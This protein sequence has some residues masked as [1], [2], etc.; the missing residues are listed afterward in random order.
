MRLDGKIAIVT[1]A[2]SGIGRATASRLAA[3][4]ASLVL[5]DL[6]PKTLDEIAQQ[7][8]K[9]HGV[10]V[11]PAPGDVSREET[12]AKIAGT[13][14]SQ[15]GRVDILVNDAGIHH[16]ADITETSLE[17]WNRVIG[18][19]LT[20]MFLVSRAIIPIML[21][22]R[23]GAIVNLASI[24]SFVGQ[25]MEGK[26]TFLYNVT[27]AGVMQL[28]T[29]LATRY[30][31]DGIRVN[32]VCPGAVK[33]NLIL[34]SILKGQERVDDSVWQAIGPSH[35]LNRCAE[36]AE[37]AAAIAFLASDDASFITGAALPV[38][39]GYLAR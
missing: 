6:N 13:A 37:I 33:T 12:A 7:I 16:V 38:D 10:K 2:G 32:C 23:A 26:S 11:A 24:S 9:Q 28:T 3:E 5:N 17:E 15:F 34:G 18:V 20:S 19:N 25:E 14:S 29:S 39:G 1:G 30:G 27:K 22:Q 35:P 4:G 8:V 36:P 31:A 21:R